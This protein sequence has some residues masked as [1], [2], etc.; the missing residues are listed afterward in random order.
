MKEIW[1]EKEFKPTKDPHSIATLIGVYA[2]LIEQVPAIGSICQKRNNLTIFNGMSYDKLGVL[3]P[4]PGK[5]NEVIIRAVDLIIT[6]IKDNRPILIWGDYDVDGMTATSV[7]YLVLKECGANVKWAIPTREQGYGM[8]YDAIKAALPT[9]G[10]I[11]TVD[12]GITG[13]AE[14]TDL[15]CD[16]YTVIITDHHLPEEDLP[17]AD[18]VVNPKCY[19]KEE[20][21][22]YMASGCYVSAQIAL[23]IAEQLLPNL[24]EKWLH[25]ANAM[26]ALSIVSDV[27]D[28]NPTMR[29]Q[30]RA[31]LIAINTTTHHGLEALIKMCFNGKNNNRNISSQGL[32]FNIVPKLNAAGRMNSVI[33]GMNVL[34]CVEDNTFGRTTAM[35]YANELRSLNSKRKLIED[36]IFN[37]ALLLP[38]ITSDDPAVVIYNPEWQTGVLGIVAARIMEQT[39]KPTIVLSGTDEISGSGRTPDGIDLHGCLTSCS[40]LLTKFGGHKVAAGVSLKKENLEK[41][42]KEFFKAVKES[43]KDCVPVYEI[44]ADVSIID[45]FDIRLTMFLENIEPTGKNNDPILFRLSDV[46]VV[47]VLNRN[48][49]LKLIVRDET[50]MNMMVEKYH[51]PDGWTQLTN[52]RVDLL[53]TP[54]ITYFTGS[55]AISWRIVAVKDITSELC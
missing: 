9:P 21:D 40:E 10:L 25:I 47:N 12:N 4:T 42:K 49:T 17:K 52:H 8:S 19:L 35:L 34:T 24:F 6:F 32:C 29:L 3:H 39:H 41:F 44:D 26:V 53:L 28:L 20:D 33:S 48:E 31:G 22:E 2:D 36:Q 38:E 1:K 54:L 46:A 11:I 55:T 16:G 18:L 43:S 23:K 27:I 7:M 50:G 51:A 14:T 37:Q 15:K 30:M 45:L 13:V 5:Y